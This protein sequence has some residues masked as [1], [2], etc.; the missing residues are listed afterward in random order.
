ML[1]P[2]RLLAFD[3][4]TAQ[5]SV[6]VFEGESLLSERIWR[7]AQSHSEYLTAEIEEALREASL[8]ARDIEALAVGQGPGSFTGIRVAINAA[9][10]LG[11]ALKT[12]VFVRDTSAILI[13]PVRRDEPV[14]TLI[15]AQKNSFFVSTFS[16]G[17]T[18][19]APTGWRRTRSL[20]FMT[21][22][23]VEALLLGGPH[24]TIGDGVELA[25]LDLK[26]EAKLN[27]I[28]DV[29]ISNFPLASSLGRL[30][31]SQQVQHPPL[32]WNAVQPLYIRASGAEEKV[33]E[34]S[35]N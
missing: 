8:H 7:R 22:S 9:R 28:R 3:T 15:N 13:E 17:E 19:H 30:T 24:L 34:G 35:K 26:P 12:P 1:R 27:L 32:D 2:K 14:L 33:R 20:E 4:S 21:L 11:Y 16:R 5:G 23:E 25:Q 18:S 31:L 29:A 10:A 6:A